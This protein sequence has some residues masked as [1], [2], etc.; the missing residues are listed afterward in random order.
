MSVAI[1][2]FINQLP[3]RN[4]HAFQ[5]AMDAVTE[6]YYHYQEP[7]SAHPSVALF[8]KHFYP[9]ALDESLSDETQN[10]LRNAIDDFVNDLDSHQHRKQLRNLSRSRAR[11]SASLTTYVNG[12]VPFTCWACSILEVSSL[13]R[14]AHHGYQPFF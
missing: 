7:T 1:L 8:L 4:I 14:G 11:N 3:S 9:Y 6:H 13:D 5:K 10:E 2:E 12:A